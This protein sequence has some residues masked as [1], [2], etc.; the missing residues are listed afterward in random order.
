MQRALGAAP[1]QPSPRKQKLGGL[2]QTQVQ[3]QSSFPLSTLNIRLNTQIVT[4][5][6][7]YSWSSQG[8]SWT[9][10]YAYQIHPLHAVKV[11]TI[12]PC[13]QRPMVAYTLEPRHMLEMA[14]GSRPSPTCGFTPEEFRTEQ[15]MLTRVS[16]SIVFYFQWETSLESTL[17]IGCASDPLGRKTM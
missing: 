4:Q 2:G 13:T 3:H 15:F 7:L 10:P 5:N 8:I 11:V 14:T 12:A 16:S 6:S 1:R 17:L 9:R